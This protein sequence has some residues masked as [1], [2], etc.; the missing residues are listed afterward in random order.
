M[1]TYYF[2]LVQESFLFNSSSSMDCPCDRNRLHNLKNISRTTSIKYLT[3]VL[4]SLS[5]EI[6]KKMVMGSYSDHFSP[7]LGPYMTKTKTAMTPPPHGTL[8]L[9]LR[10]F[11]LVT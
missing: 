5:C 6:V 4:L 3:G 9:P 2:E 1:C 8:C 10:I 11:G 7:L